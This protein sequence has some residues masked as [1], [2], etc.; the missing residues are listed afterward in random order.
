MATKGKSQAVK[1][2]GAVL[3]LEAMAGG[4]DNAHQVL[5]VPALPPSLSR[6]L[7]L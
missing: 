7:T 3:T 1:A 2:G 6:Q 4:F 5:P